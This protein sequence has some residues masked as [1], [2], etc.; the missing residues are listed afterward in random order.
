MILQNRLLAK[1]PG[2]ERHL[3]VAII[4]EIVKTGMIIL[5]QLVE[6]QCLA[7]QRPGFDPPVQHE[8]GMVLHIYNSS[9]QEVKTVGSKVQSHPQLPSDFEGHLSYLY[10]TLCQ[11]KNGVITPTGVWCLYYQ[12][13]RTWRF[14]VF[15]PS[16][17]NRRVESGAEERIWSTSNFHRQPSFPTQQALPLHLPWQTFWTAQHWLP[18]S[19]R[20]LKRHAFTF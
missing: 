11:N 7:W 5:A 1:A 17:V 6:L 10:E 4:L 12:P 3:K 14:L 19:P 9:T 8:L 13:Q 16:A 20:W 2:L 18:R 15:Y